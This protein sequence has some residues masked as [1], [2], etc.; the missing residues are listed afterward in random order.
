MPDLFNI[1]SGYIEQTGD[2]LKDRA[3]VEAALHDTDSIDR[4]ASNGCNCELSTDAIERISAV[5]LAWLR[6]V[7]EGNGEWDRMQREARA[8]LEAQEA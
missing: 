3:A 5:G 6:D 8:A 4:Y 7:H 1:L 2:M